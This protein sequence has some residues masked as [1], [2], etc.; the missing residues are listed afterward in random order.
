MFI[1][2]K[3]FKD[4]DDVFIKIV[5]VVKNGVFKFISNG[6]VILIVKVF[7]NIFKFEK[8]LEK[9][10]VKL[11]VDFINIM[12]KYVLVD[13]NKGLFNVIFNLEKLKGNLLLG[14]CGFWG[15]IRGKV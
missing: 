7:D 14:V 4:N 13:E 9:V 3:E 1:V 5:E 6:N 11:Y 12:F 2:L 10:D 8:F 15:V